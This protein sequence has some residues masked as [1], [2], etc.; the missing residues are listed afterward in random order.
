MHLW[1]KHEEVPFI[2][3]YR[4]AL[5]ADLRSLREDDVPRTTTASEATDAYPAGTLQVMKVGCLT[6]GLKHAACLVSTDA[7]QRRYG[8][9]GGPPPGK[10]RPHAYGNLHVLGELQRSASPSWGLW[11]G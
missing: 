6:C 5:A 4:K 8:A 9:G 2:A 1:E 3:A 7:V 10:L 11:L